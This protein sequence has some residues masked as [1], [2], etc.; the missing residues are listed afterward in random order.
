[1]DIGGRQLRGGCANLQRLLH[2]QEAL[3]CRLESRSLRII[4]IRAENIAL[5]LVLL[6]G[7]EQVIRGSGPEGLKTQQD[8]GETREAAVHLYR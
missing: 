4:K 3:I 8:G 6:T 1:M 7:A 5:S 2:R